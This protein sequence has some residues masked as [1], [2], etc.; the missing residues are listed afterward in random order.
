MLEERLCRLIK[1]FMFQYFDEQFED[2]ISENEHGPVAPFDWLT[3]EKQLDL[4]G[5][6]RVLKASRKLRDNKAVS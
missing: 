2:T 3:T 1:L 5:K 4:N 6:I